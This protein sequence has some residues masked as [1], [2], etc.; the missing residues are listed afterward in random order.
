MAN[1]FVHVELNTGDLAV[2]R[3]FYKKLFDWKLEDMPMGEGQSYT[4][5]SVGKGVAGGMQAKPMPDAPTQWLPYVQVD[6]IKR[7]IAKARKLGAHIVV[8]HMP[9]ADMGALGIFVDPTGA[10]LGLWQPAKAP[11]RRAKR[12]AKRA[13]KK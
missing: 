9:V 10:V 6:S 7:S 3:A 8:E 13:K 4:M 11:A 1:P 12:P 2:A 5:I